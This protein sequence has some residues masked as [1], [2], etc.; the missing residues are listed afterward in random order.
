[1]EKYAKN[2]SN[3]K[4]TPN[5]L[6]NDVFNKKVDD[7]DLSI[8]KIEKLKEKFRDCLFHLNHILLLTP[9]L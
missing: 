2:N 5:P 8:F 9:F 7:F 3:V 4:D 6:R 1:M